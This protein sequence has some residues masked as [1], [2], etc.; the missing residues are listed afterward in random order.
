MLDEIVVSKNGNFLYFEGESFLKLVFTRDPATGFE[1]DELGYIHPSQFSLLNAESGISC[2]SSEEF[3]HPLGVR[4]ASS[5]GSLL[6]ASDQVNIYF[7]NS[8]HKL[9]ISTQI[10]L[11][12]FKQYKASN[13]QSDKVVDSSYAFLSCDH[14]ESMLM[15]HSRP[16]LLLSCD[17]ITAWNCRWWL[18]SKEIKDELPC[19]ESLMRLVS[20]MKTEQRLLLKI[21]GLRLYEVYLLV[22]ILIF[23]S[24]GR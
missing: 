18:R 5:V 9:G 1:S 17:F 10:L 22:T 7:W 13:N 12:A 14:L 16:L 3:L 4:T 21:L 24:F 6:D 15:R 2:G 19:L 20:H 23:T 8:D 11:Q